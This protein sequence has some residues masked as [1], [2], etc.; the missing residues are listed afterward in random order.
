MCVFN[1]ASLKSPSTKL[2]DLMVVDSLN[3]NSSAM[4]IW[5]RLAKCKL[6][7]KSSST[8]PDDLAGHKFTKCN[9]NLCKSFAKSPSTKLGDL[10]GHKLTKCNVSP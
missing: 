2:G 8:K 9:V 4:W 6:F 10:A 1:K 5:H 7:A 3:W